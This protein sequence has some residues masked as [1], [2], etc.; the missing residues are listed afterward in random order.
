MV[1][2]LSSLQENKRNL[3]LLLWLETE[4]IDHYTGTQKIWK[5]RMNNN[6]WTICDINALLF[7]CFLCKV[8]YAKR[9]VS[10][11]NRYIWLWSWSHLCD[12]FYQRLHDKLTQRTYSSHFGVKCQK[13]EI[14][15]KLKVL[16]QYLTHL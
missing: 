1:K 8:K 14:D 9:H 3:I 7:V 4:S 2:K 13:P 6:S 15:L 10:T 12:I 11:N 16:I 5:L